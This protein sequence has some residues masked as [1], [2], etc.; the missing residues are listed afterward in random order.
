L[1]YFSRW[2][3]DEGMEETNNNFKGVRLHVHDWNYETVIEHEKDAW[4]IGRLLRATRK[5]L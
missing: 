3:C 2:G 5:W 1:D 4:K